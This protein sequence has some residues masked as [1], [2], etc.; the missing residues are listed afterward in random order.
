[1]PRPRVRSV[2]VV[3]ALIT[4]GEAADR[5]RVCFLAL[6][7]AR[8]TSAVIPPAAPMMQPC[9]PVLCLHGQIQSSATH[10]TGA[11]R[12]HHM[13]KA[14]VAATNHDPGP[15]LAAERGEAEAE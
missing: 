11:D 14:K 7:P 1:M 12:L 4:I 10:V 3:P 13:A 5:P 9:F 8:Q 2:A 15:Q 6:C